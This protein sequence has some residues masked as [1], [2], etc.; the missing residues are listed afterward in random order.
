MT[1]YP[2]NLESQKT[3]SPPISLTKATLCFLIRGDE[4]LLARKKRGF[5]R[6]LWNGAGGK[7]LV[8]ESI[9]AAMKR[10]TREE[11]GVAVCAWEKV[12]VL[13]FYFIDKP[14]WNQQVWAF[15]CEEWEGEPQESE[16]MAPQWFNQK[17]LPFEK[18]WADDG[19]WLP[20]VLMSKKIRGDFLF[21]QLG[22][23]L[24]SKLEETQDFLQEVTSP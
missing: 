2:E 5:G 14:D 21:N 9:E 22:E 6:G 11:I 8:G 23:I 24:E 1:Q 16:E 10:E 13:N 15:F 7:V 3:Q 12:A 18:M 20:E 4:I 17:E 19:L